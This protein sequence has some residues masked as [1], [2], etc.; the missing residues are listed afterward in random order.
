MG[1]SRGSCAPPQVM[2]TR[3]SA[4]MKRTL[5]GAP[6]QPFATTLFAPARTLRAS[7]GQRRA[8]ACRKLPR[9]WLSR[10]EAAAYIGVSPT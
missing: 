8:S 3:A 7:T 5:L 6:A 4:P 2:G 1:Q 10:V 9:R